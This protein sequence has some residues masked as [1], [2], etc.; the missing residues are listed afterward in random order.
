[1]SIAHVAG[2]RSLAPEERNV[3]LTKLN[4]SLLRSFRVLW[5]PGSINIWSLR[6]RRQAARK[7]DRLSHC[8]RDTTLGNRFSQQHSVNTLSETFGRGGFVP[9]H[10]SVDK[11]RGRSGHAG[12]SATLNV[13][14]NP[15]IYEIAVHVAGE[16]WDL[17]V[18]LPGVRN[19]DR[20]GIVLID[21]FLLVAV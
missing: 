1:M 13:S 20:A 19:E 2:E 15:L 17:E 6:D 12:R 10:V 21:P 5:N 4:I 18:E 16:F 7:I 14:A 11:N 9:Q 8:F 3:L